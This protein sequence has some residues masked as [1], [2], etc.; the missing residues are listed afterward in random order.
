MIICVCI[1]GLWFCER[2]CTKK[3]MYTYFS[4]QCITHDLVMP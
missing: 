2:I 3:Y 1:C 4:S